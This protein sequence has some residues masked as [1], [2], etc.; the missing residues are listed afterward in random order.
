MS[1]RPFLFSPARFLP[2]ALLCMAGLFVCTNSQAADGAPG[3]V[4]EAVT[5]RFYD[6][7]L[8]ALTQNRDPIQDEPRMLEA[9]VTRALVAEIHRRMHDPDGLDSDYFIR[10][11]D[12]LDEWLGN[13][14]TSSVRMQGQTATLRVTL[15]NSAATLHRLQVDLIIEDGHWKIRRVR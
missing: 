4:P 7:Y 8:Q 5:I 11:Q 13:I 10:A 15:G 3:K 12:Y 6:W 9:F 2:I 14:A 1:T